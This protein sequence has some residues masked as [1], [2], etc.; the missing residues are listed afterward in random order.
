VHTH[1]KYPWLKEPSRLGKV[2]RL[3][4]LLEIIGFAAEWKSVSWPGLF[5]VKYI[6]EVAI[7]HLIH[8]GLPKI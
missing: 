1:L 6:P 4:N 2:P 3:V 8:E 7:P 5:R